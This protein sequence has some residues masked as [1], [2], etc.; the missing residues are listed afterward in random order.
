M[1]E[2]TKSERVMAAIRGEP[3][4]RVPMSFYE[5]ND[6][7]ERSPDVLVPHL[8]EQN[9]KFGWDFLKIQ[10]RAGVASQKYVDKVV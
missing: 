1:P 2:M 3:I 6:A 5:H 9:R 8:L 7:A 4:D 10:C